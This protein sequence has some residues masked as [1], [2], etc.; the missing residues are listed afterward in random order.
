MNATFYNFSHK[1]RKR[2]VKIDL[3]NVPTPA[4]QRVEDDL[5]ELQQQ[6]EE[7]IT[8]ATRTTTQQNILPPKKVLPSLPPQKAVSLPTLPKKKHAKDMTKRHL[9]Y[10][11]VCGAK[12]RNATAL[13]GHITYFTLDKK[14][15]CELCGHRSLYLAH[16]KR[17][18]KST[19]K[20]TNLY[21]LDQMKGCS[22]C[23]KIGFATTKELTIHKMA[24]Q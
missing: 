12:T 17:H 9:G 7:V 5:E 8:P 20:L 6:D 13:H 2:I 22:L 16:L 4:P 23:G 3:T 10:Y 19:H 11:C 21:Q 24:T 14:F 18:L 1:K 15:E